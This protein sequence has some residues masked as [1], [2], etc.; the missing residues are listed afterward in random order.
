[1]IIMINNACET[2]C[3]EGFY[4]IFLRIG[5]PLG[6]VRQVIKI[7]SHIHRHYMINRVMF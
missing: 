3:D 2:E 6:G 7:H 1:M 5:N 4:S